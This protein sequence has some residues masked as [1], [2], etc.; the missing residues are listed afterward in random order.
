MMKIIEK[1]HV[2][3]LNHIDGTGT[4]RLVFVNRELGT[5]HEGTQTQE[6]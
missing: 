1:G 6:V 3:E 4:Q 2:Y 5:E